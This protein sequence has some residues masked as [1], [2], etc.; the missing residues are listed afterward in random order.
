MSLFRN[1]IQAGIT[2]LDQGLGKSILRIALL[3]MLGA[4]IYCTYAW[5][6]FRGLDDPQAMEYAQIARNLATGK[7]FTTQC[8]RPVDLWRP[9]QIGS[10]PAAITPT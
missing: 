6:Q 10:Q 9:K 3:L 8:I 7:G 2:S 4:G 1:S 5:S